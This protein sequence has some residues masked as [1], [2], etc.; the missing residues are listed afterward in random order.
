MNRARTRAQR[1]VPIALA[2]MFAFVALVLV[3]IGVALFW[4]GVVVLLGLGVCAVVV[5]SVRNRRLYEKSPRYPVTFTA[6][7]FHV[8][9]EPTRH[10]GETYR[11]LTTS[12]T[13]PRL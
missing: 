8:P 5:R 3:W 12:L 6:S 10:N 2:V 4:P 13:W 11:P 7:Q 9:P 1:L